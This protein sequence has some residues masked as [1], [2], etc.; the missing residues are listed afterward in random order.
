[1]FSRN[2]WIHPGNK[3]KFCVM[4]DTE[5]SDS[6]GFFLLRLASSQNGNFTL[7]HLTE[8]ETLSFFI[9]SQFLPSVLPGLEEAVIWPF[10]LIATDEVRYSSKA[11]PRMVTWTAVMN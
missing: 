3:R 8:I 4:Y 2:L 10:L 1:M 5:E 7:T 9:P 6:R 11:L